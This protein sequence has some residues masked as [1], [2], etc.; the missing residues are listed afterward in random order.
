M[1]DIY[2]GICRY[3]L[4]SILNSFIKNKFFSFE[5][6]NE[7]IKFFNYGMY[8]RNTVPLIKADHIKRC[9]IIMSAAEMACFVRYLGLIVGDKIPENNSA[10]QIFLLL[11]QIISIVTSP[12]IQESTPKLLKSLIEE[13]HSFYLEIFTNQTLKPKHHIITHYPE[14]IIRVGPLINISSMRFEAKH[15]DL[16]KNANV[17]QSRVNITFTLAKKN[18]LQLCEKFLSKRGFSDNI[19][20][21]PCLEVNDTSAHYLWIEINGIKYFSN[22][23]PILLISIDEPL[24]EFGLISSIICYED[25]R[26]TFTLK[27]LFTIGYYS[28]VDAYEVTSDNFVHSVEID[29]NSLINIFP[30]SGILYY[31]NT[32]DK[33]VCFR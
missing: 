15:R 32:D 30:T 11:K 29:F 33:F 26:I 9:Q 25:E 28:H 22:R 31:G 6:L 1:H 23:N 5:F 14:I 27:K 8:E 18:Q 4:G 17:V 12:T 2:E 3:E 19:T 7:R 10:W 13:H 16:K 24:P 20:F 21:G